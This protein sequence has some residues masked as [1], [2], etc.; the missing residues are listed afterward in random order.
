M[1]NT[2]AKTGTRANNE[3]YV[4]AAASAITRFSVKK[5]TVRIIFRTT[6]L[7]IAPLTTLNIYY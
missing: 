3:E 6:C 1:A 7:I 2:T 4:K 5:R